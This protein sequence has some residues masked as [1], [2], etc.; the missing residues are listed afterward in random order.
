M[1]GISP[2]HPPPPVREAADAAAALVPEPA[3]REAPTN[4]PPRR[5]SRLE[6]FPH[7]RGGTAAGPG[8]LPPERGGNPSLLVRAATPVWEPV[9]RPSG[10][11]A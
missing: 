8:P 10:A 7:L 11:L 2:P 3:R 1:V 9:Y 4:L 6:R 5:A